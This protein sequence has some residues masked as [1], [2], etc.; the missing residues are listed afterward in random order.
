MAA[1]RRETKLLRGQDTYRGDSDRCPER[2]GWS[3]EHPGLSG[4]Y[5]ANYLRDE[6]ARWTLRPRCD[7]FG[8]KTLLRSSSGLRGTL[9]PQDDGRYELNRRQRAGSCQ[10]GFVDGT[11]RTYGIY[12]HTRLWLTV[13]RRPAPDD[14]GLQLDGRRTS[15]HDAPADDFNLCNI[16]AKCEAGRVRARRSGA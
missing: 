14:I 2:D 12:L 13:S 9:V 16:A 5:H 4:H 10:V 15:W 7:V 3:L 1:E 8:C 11:T 6:A